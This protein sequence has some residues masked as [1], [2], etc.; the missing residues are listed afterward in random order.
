MQSFLRFLPVLITAVLTT[1]AAAPTRSKISADRKVAAI[2]KNH[3]PANGAIAFSVP[4]L[5]ALGMEQ[6]NVNLPGVLSKPELQLAKG[7]ATATAL[8]NFDK[9][10]QMRGQDE[11]SSDWLVSKMLNG[12]RKVTVSGDL[13]SGGGKMTV[14]PTRVSIAGVEVSGSALDMLIKTFVTS[15]YPNAVIDKPFVLPN[16]ISR[17][18]VDPAAAVAHRK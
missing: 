17:V 18:D 3:W 15:R 1:Q 2:Q 11:P 14:H 6:A 12:Q 4:E 5:I 7:A 8:V 9:L 10:E 16:H 13:T